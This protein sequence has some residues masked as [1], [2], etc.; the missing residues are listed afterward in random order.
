MRRIEKLTH[1][2]KMEGQGPGARAALDV[3]AFAD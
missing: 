3:G 2:I 1:M